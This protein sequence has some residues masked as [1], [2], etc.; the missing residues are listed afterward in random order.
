MP[1][2]QKGPFLC[3]DKGTS[4]DK[5][6]QAITSSEGSSSTLK[7]SPRHPLEGFP[8]NIKGIARCLVKKSRRDYPDTPFGTTLSNYSLE[9]LHHYPVDS[10][11]SPRAKLLRH[12]NL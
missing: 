8:P 6:K 5:K 7:R 11:P 12:K 2:M 1:A 4:P 9:P 10:S 3:P